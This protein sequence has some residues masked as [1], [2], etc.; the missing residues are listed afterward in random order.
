MNND[1]RKSI[2]TDNPYANNFQDFK[3]RRQNDK[4]LTHINTGKEIWFFK[5]EILKDI[6]NIEKNLTDKFNI[7][8]IDVKDEIKTIQENIKSLDIKL[9][10]LTTKITEDNSIKE[11]IHNL[12]N[13]KTKILDDILVNDMKVNHLDRELRQNIVD[14]NNTLKESVLYAGVIGP[15]C[16]F[17]T[18]HDLID[19]IINELNILGTFKEKNMLDLNAFKK[20]IESSVSGFKMQLESFGRSSTQYTTD[21]FNKME[22]IMHE[23]FHQCDDKIDEIRSNF[24]ER[25]RKA[26]ENIDDI[27]K[28]VIME[29]NEIKEKIYSLEKNMNNHNK[30][31]LHLKEDMN[32]LNEN[33]TKRLTRRNSVLSNM[34]GNNTNNN[35]N[36]KKIKKRKSIIG[37]E[38]KEELKNNE[39][40]NNSN[41]SININK[42]N[43]NNEN[44][45]EQNISSEEDSKKISPIRT[46]MKPSKEKDNSKQNNDL[47]GLFYLKQN[48]KINVESSN[49]LNINKYL[50]DK[51]KKRTNY[52]NTHTYNKTRLLLSSLDQEAEIMRTFSPKRRS[53]K[54]INMK[55]NLN[56][57]HHSNELE[58]SKISVKSNDN[59]YNFDVI[60]P[61]N[62]LNPNQYSQ[63]KPKIDIKTPSTNKNIF[64]KTIKSFQQKNKLW[65]LNKEKRNLKRKNSINNIKS[66]NIEKNN[67]KNIFNDRYN[68]N[69][70]KANKSSAKFKNIILTLEGTKKMV[71]ENKDFKK[72]KNLYY[73]ESLSEKNRKKSY[74]RERLESCKV[75]LKK[76]YKKDIKSY[77]L[78]EKEEPFDFINYKNHKILLMS[79]SA[80]SRAYINNKHSVDYD[81][82]NTNLN[83]NL[84]PSF[85][86]TKYNFPQKNRN[87][88]S[89]EKSLQT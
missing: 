41:N 81:Y 89:E 45:E 36:K 19:F 21:N 85:N 60:K 68:Y 46:I 24:N 86:V 65:L 5:N 69:Y 10:E 7:A 58:N 84:S 35:L 62:L 63:E 9:K 43:D 13:I 20:R 37:N 17:K 31:Y 18:F 42:N 25:S 50:K 15:S 51:T 64:N 6:K 23:L 33:M 66:L 34:E 67:I 27:E 53:I 47:S 39:T 14:M 1:K 88:N 77:Y 80:S 74:L 59:I 83:N 78:S 8:D 4:A 2:S 87:K 26:E 76:N 11:K 3:F 55:N 29:I 22:R 71:Y 75:L 28:K 16:K 32:K 30:Q 57:S 73:I 12:D 61:L 44:K 54:I 48:L 52:E 70:P 40:D 56:V 79:K 72:G 38:K 82:N 49:F